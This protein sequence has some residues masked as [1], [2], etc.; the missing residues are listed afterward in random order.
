M[1]ATYRNRAVTARYGHDTNIN[2]NTNYKNNNKYNISYNYSPKSL[3]FADKPL[4]GDWIHCIRCG[5][6]LEPSWNHH[7]TMLEPQYSI[8]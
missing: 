8:E 2:Y 6:R 3:Y 4:G 1:A 5:S 7:G